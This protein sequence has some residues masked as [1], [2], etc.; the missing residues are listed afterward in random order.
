MKSWK[1][2]FQQPGPLEKPFRDWE[3]IWSRPTIEI[4][5][6]YITSNEKWSLNYAFLPT[7]TLDA[8]WIWLKRFY[9]LREGHEFGAWETRARVLHRSCVRIKRPPNPF[10]LFRGMNSSIRIPGIY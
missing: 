8:G 2:Y 4:V 10:D 6:K 1:P 9:T 7:K 3:E 5:F